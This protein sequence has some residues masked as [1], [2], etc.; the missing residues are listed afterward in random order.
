MRA[1][2]AF[3]AD[4]CFPYLY[5]CCFSDSL[6]DLFRGELPPW[7]NAQLCQCLIFGWFYLFIMTDLFHYT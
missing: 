2:C 4:R 5:D 1:A 3:S 6:D 7:R